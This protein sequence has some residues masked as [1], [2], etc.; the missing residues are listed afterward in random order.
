M[1]GVGLSKSTRLPRARPEAFRLPFFD[2]G[3]FIP[4]EGAI[5]NWKILEKLSTFDGSPRALRKMGS[6]LFGVF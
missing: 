2:S 5:W 6:P 1:S 4:P 3:F